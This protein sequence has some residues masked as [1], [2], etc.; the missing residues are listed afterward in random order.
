M[1]TMQQ[2]YRYPNGELALCTPHIETEGVAVTVNTQRG[3]YNNADTVANEDEALAYWQ[4]HAH[5]LLSQTIEIK[6]IN[7]GKYDN[8]EYNF[9]I[10]LEAFCRLILNNIE[11]ARHK[12]QAN[13]A[14]GEDNEHGEQGPDC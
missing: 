2:G 8:D 12:G 5:W 13:L 7:C 11:K 4:K 9:H 3:V 1:L 10:N 6:V 14:N